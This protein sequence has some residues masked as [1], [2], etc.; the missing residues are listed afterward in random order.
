MQMADKKTSDYV[1]Q[2]LD[3]SK[4][5]E[6]KFKQT[7]DIVFNLK[8]IDMDDSKNRI[9]EEIILPH[10]R[11]KDAKIA[12]FASGELALKAKG[13]VDLVIKPEQIEDLAG[14][15]KK[16]KKIVD[17]YDFFIAEAPLM[18]T[19]GKTLGVVLGPRGKMPRPVPPQVEIG[20]IVKNLRN[21]IKV[22]SKTNKT[23]HAI[24][25]TEEM[26]S[27]DIADNIDT[28]MKRVET[29]LER[30]RMNIGSVYVK[31]TMGPSVRIL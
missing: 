14:D 28:I 29:K 20:G 4:K 13:K 25:G 9:E 11:G 24:A 6:R 5:L 21:T 18:P 8:N 30:G 27:K 3:G 23:F 10:G 22:R 2:A 26:P 1:Q 19:I 12:I 15:K 31:T 17:Q 16:F 7:V